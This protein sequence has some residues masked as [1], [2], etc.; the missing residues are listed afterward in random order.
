MIAYPHTDKSIL[1]T[2]IVTSCCTQKNTCC[3]IVQD[4]VTVL[5]HGKWSA[6]RTTCIHNTI[7][8]SLFIN[9]GLAG[10]VVAAICIF[11]HYRH[12][13][14]RGICRIIFIKFGCPYCMNDQLAN[15][16][17]C[18]LY[19]CSLAITVSDLIVISADLS[20]FQTVFGPESIPA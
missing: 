12:F 10:F 15:F 8:R 1:H 14:Q 9:S 4:L 16:F 5:D 2:N 19:R 17:L 13:F 18:I 6:C 20:A 7:V 3:S 11:G